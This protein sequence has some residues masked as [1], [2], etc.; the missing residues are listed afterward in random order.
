MW[1]FE[2]YAFDFFPFV[3]LSTDYVWL[4]FGSVSWARSL[5]YIWFFFAGICSMSWWVNLWCFELY[6]FDFIFCVMLSTDCA[7][8]VVWFC[9]LS[10]ES[11]LYLSC[12]CLKVFVCMVSEFVVLWIVRFW[13]SFLCIVVSILGLV[14]CMV[15]WAE[16]GDYIILSVLF[17]FCRFC[18]ISDSGLYVIYL[19]RLQYIFIVFILS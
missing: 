14:G 9:E 18:T 7:W 10:K 3:L 5:Y 1:C 19:F 16:Q 6:A 4:L 13:F 2:M 15:L 12:F 8:F 11:M 17:F